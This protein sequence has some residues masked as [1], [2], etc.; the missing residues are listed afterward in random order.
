MSSKQ[1]LISVA[2]EDTPEEAEIMK[3]RS[4]LMITLQEYI[5]RSGLNQLESAK[6]FG[7]TRPRISNL[8]R[9]KINL[10]TLDVL[11]KM[12]STAGL[13]VEM[14]VIEAV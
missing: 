8:M 6:L 1:Q 14:W 7:V 9:G 12:A 3:L 11:V 5:V 10:L 4:I 2:F 13:H